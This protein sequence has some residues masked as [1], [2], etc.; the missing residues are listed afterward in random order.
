MICPTFR[1]WPS[2]SM[3]GCLVLA[4]CHWAHS[5]CPSCPGRKPRET[6]E[7]PLWCHG[8]HTGTFYF[9]VRLLRK[10]LHVV[11]DEGAMVTSSF[12]LLA[13]WSQLIPIAFLNIDKFTT[14]CTLVDCLV[15][16]SGFLFFL[17][18]VWSYLFPVPDRV[19]NLDI[20]GTSGLG[21][22]WFNF[23]HEGFTLF[24]S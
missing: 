10:Y 7:V 1:L 17:S 12:R 3:H 15:K 8:H 11:V 20:R 6:L 18:R 14:V 22:F 23:Y 9:H 5:G 16:P 13:T 4:R 19:W 21:W 24:Y 2:P